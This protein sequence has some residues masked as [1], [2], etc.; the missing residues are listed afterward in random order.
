MSSFTES[1][2]EETALEWLKDMGYTIVFGNDIAPDEPAAERENYGEVILSGR[3]KDALRRINP[4][5]PNEAL[6]D[7]FRKATRPSSPALV[8]NNR[9][10][11]KMLADG[12]EVEYR[13][14]GR[15][16]GDK[17]WL[18]DFENLENNDWL[19]V[20]QFTIVENHINRRPD[21]LIFINGLPLSVIELKNAADTKATI[22]S[23]FKQLQTY[24]NEISSLFVYN[25]ALVI[26]DGTHARIGSLTADKERFMPWKT[27]EGDTLADGHE[28]ELEVLLRGTFNKRRFLDLIRY[29]VVFEDDGVGQP[30][31]K[32]AGYHQFHAVN[33]AIEQTV[34]ASMEK[35]HKTGEL[36]GT[37][38]THQPRDAKPGD[39]RIGVI[40]HTQGS[41]KSLTMAF[42]A[43][44]MVLHPAMENPT[45]VVI[46]DRN[47]LDDQLFGTFSRCKDLLRQTPVQAESRDDL[48]DK[49]RK[50]A[51]GG[52]IFTT[53]Q[54]FVAGAG[55]LSERRN[56]VVIADEAHRSQYDFIDGNARTMRDALPNAS[57]IG[58]TGT[59]IEL[60][61]ANTR[62]VFGDYISV[63]DIQQAVEDGATVPIYYEGRLAKLE[64]KESEKPKI[65]P[66]F[67]EL[68]EGEETGDKEKLKTKWAALE[69]IVGSDNRVDLIAQDLLQ[70]FDARLEVIEGKA[71]I[72][73]MSR[74]ICVDLYTAITKLRPEWHSTDD[75]QGV[76]KVVM[77]GSASDDADWQIHI[78]NKARREKLAMRFKDSK[79]PFKIAIVR[80][81][82]LTG[83]DVPSLH[84]MYIDKPMKGHGLMQAIARV[85]RVYGDKPGGL[86]VD[87]LG[88]AFHLQQALANYTESGG[89][90]N[91]AIDQE[92]AVAV[93]LREYEICR[94]MFHGFDYSKWKQGKG[95][96]QLSLLNWA[97]EHILQQEN[98]KQRY[99]QTVTK[100]SQAF[101]LAVPNDKALAIRDDVGFFQAVRARI[102][103]SSPE[104]ELQAEDIEHAIRQII[105]RAVA[106]DE[107]ID[108]F[109]A[110]G[111]KKPDISILSDEFL[112]DVQNMPQKNVAIELLRKLLTDE[113]KLR[114]RKNVVQSRSFLEM[115]ERTIHA[116]QNRAI[117]VA[118]VISELIELG[119]EMREA[120]KRGDILNLS[121]DE[122]AFYDALEVNDSAVKVLGN[123]TLKDIARELVKS[124][125]ENATI[126]WTMKENVRAKLRVMV[127]R[128]L[129]KYGYPPD[130][131]EKATVTVLEQ[132]EVIAKDWAG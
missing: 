90:G 112:A 85:N 98:G 7:A 10:F 93:A 104:H 3:L 53:I 24:K 97:Q 50:S 86:I 117:E 32:M 70:H 103:K 91:T 77:T 118:Q 4:D 47:D 49:L 92:E 130:K 75:T 88:L 114:S 34:R 71:M 116:Y 20:N 56:I 105:S 23:A 8:G 69:S 17:V 37:Y 83:F 21:I 38:A 36:H 68:T 51:S 107:V 123:D 127:R 94:D 45:I 81:M 41:G 120:S 5:V 6:E 55:A 31:K 132:A 25:E 27:V 119:R 113:I 121:E 125:R 61:D 29:F 2:I 33:M 18:I 14:E 74:R 108:I 82:W 102:I 62:A 66:E 13:H 9:A 63:Y 26:S 11:H 44:R 129:R 106:S 124:V 111:L 60:K 79:D 126:D 19:A 109:K 73:C 99:T 30:I 52:I 100:L 122:L 67:E 131:R 57:F 12:I 43:G 16:K 80:D 101:A 1:T 35:G 48:T 54:K 76:I 115:L 46:T 95:E 84:T 39:R 28:I 110:A 65:D 128:I 89:K 72:V 96:E 58:F 78:R 22:W 42:Y 40:W 87:Y 59:P 64:L 15:I